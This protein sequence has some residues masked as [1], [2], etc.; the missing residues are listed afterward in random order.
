M[1]ALSLGR[2]PAG[3]RLGGDGAALPGRGG[4]WRLRDWR[5]RT[6]LTA[7]L[8]L[9]LLLAGVLGALRVTELVGEAR[10]LA[11]LAR[12]VGFA[13]Q[14][15]LVVH[16]LQ[17]ERHLA[18]AMLVTGRA[19]DGD[20][21]QAQIQR[22]DA[23]VTILRTAD[24]G[25]DA[26]QAVGGGQG[27]AAHQAAL[28]RL[29]GLPALRQ[30]TVGQV[31]PN[32]SGRDAITAYSDLIAVLLELDRWVLDGAG[33]SLAA[34]AAGLKA[35][36][37]AKEQVSQQHA[38]LLTG[39]LS[40]V[41]SADQQAALRT[42]QARFDAAVDEFGQ[43]VP[44]P[45]RGLYSNT[46]AVVDRKRLLD[47]ALDRATRRA[48][49]G[50]APGDWNAAAVGTVE[51]IRQG[52]TTL[53]NE[54]QTDTAA[55]SDRAWRDALWEGVAV[56][57]LLV[58]AVLALVVVVRSLLRRLRTLRTAAFDVAD[59]RLP[60]AVEQ[61]RSTDGAAGQTT[62]DPVPVH[63]REE[64][65]Q[66]ARAFDTVHAQ[67]VRLAA[68]QAVARNSL[69]NIFLNLSGR[70]QG[71]VDRQRQLIDEL[72]SRQHDPELLNSLFQ[73]DHLAARM[74]RHSENLL[75]LAGGE[76]PRGVG[77]RV[78]VLDVL[79]SAV[80]EIEKYQRVT[81]RR[82]PAATVAAPVVN[83]LVHL[84]A[85]LLDN[86]TS[87]TPQE[88]TVDLAGDLTE[89]E[90]LLVEI[91]DFGPGL[92]SDELQAING[93]LASPPAVDASVSRQMGLFVV[94]TLA[95]RHGI[96]V[97]LRQRL[98][99]NGLGD[100]GIT[101]TVLLPPS[102]V[103]IDSPASIDTAPEVPAATDWSGTD[104]QLPLQV[105]VIDEATAADLF[106][107]ASIDVVTSQ[108]SRPRTAEQEWQE[109]FGYQPS[110]PERPPVPDP[111]PS[112][113]P[114]VGAVA[115]KPSEVREEIF[116]MVSAWFR[117]RQATPVSSY[118]LDD[119]TELPALRGGFPSSV[120]AAAAPPPS[121]AH[122][123]RSPLDEAW[124]AAQALRT[125]V[126][127]GVT[128]AGLPKRQPRAHL[129]VGADGA[130]RLV[131][132]PAPGPARTPDAVR[133]RLSRYQ[134][135]LRVGRH[136]RFSPDEQLAMTDIPQG[137]FEEDQQ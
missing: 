119:T 43:A 48:P 94:S 106:S 105:S 59:R 39:I 21:L 98:G 123:W 70:N 32:V 4:R 24:L 37:V 91:I 16:D 87:V 85:E 68:E 6:K 65:G 12:Q 107:P 8:L 1:T 108:R 83:D 69:N 92:P 31:G 9:P 60:E 116:E 53:L 45:Q 114:Q 76:L 52:E 84:I 120:S 118:Q 3:A 75:V 128:R 99:N 131:A 42:A 56:A 109:L 132:T 121:N 117:E 41:L 57:A 73:V 7:V 78:A 72:C 77:E 47:A 74:R 129:V 113:G 82:S 19:A 34:Q 96:T 54:L 79:R 55:R 50:T 29:S 5:L 134:R 126:D 135:G 115:G 20:A 102:L 62:V 111:L 15:G 27:A 36:A 64:V 58:L 61:L 88:I 133:G 63:S 18:A 86:A 71:L 101:A 137:R 40:G 10:D 22:V 44:A 90:G 28:D 80:S 14:V 67:A 89:D 81:V 124:H 25:A 112:S 110:Q 127:H 46:G 104:G 35:L 100:I 93:R 95:A 51:A 33:D 13:K 30:A 66:V 26:L 49:L 136:A 11:T 2:A 130:S 125:P 38:V 122:E 103:L 23:A 97:R 17:Q